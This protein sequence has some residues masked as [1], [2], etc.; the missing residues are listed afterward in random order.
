MPSDETESGIQY[1]HDDA[2]YTERVARR[3]ER[4]GLESGYISAKLI[5]P[6]FPRDAYTA[7]LISS[8]KGWAIF[9]S[10][11]TKAT[12]WTLPGNIGRGLLRY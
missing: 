10:V 5:C 6:V 1:P 11:I 4:R 8:Q 12:S 9:H 3:C 2:D 7:Q